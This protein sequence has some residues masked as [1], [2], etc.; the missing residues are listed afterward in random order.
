[1]GGGG[2][3]WFRRSQSASITVLSFL[4]RESNLFYCYSRVAAPNGDLTLIFN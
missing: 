3:G 2:V 1:L 4:E